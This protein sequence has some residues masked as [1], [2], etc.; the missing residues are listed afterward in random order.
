MLRATFATL[1]GYMFLI[2]FPA[3][4]Q[5]QSNLRAAEE[6]YDRARYDSSLSLLDTHTTDPAS[7]FLIGRDYYMLADFK[8]A[9]KFLKRA[10]RGRPE[11]SE[12]ADWLGRA[13]RA[14]ADTSNPLSAVL[15]T[16]RVR[17]SFERAVQLNPKNAG[18]LADLFYCYLET[19]VFLGGGSEKAQSIAEKMSAVDPYQASSQ[20]WEVAQKWHAKF[21]VTIAQEPPANK[22]QPA[23]LEAAGTQ[24]PL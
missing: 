7:L 3:F 5:N 6:L 1:I 15:L 18:A 10:V 4:A 16:K 14:R 12:Y 20:Q 8:R 9:A 17:N 11:S 2:S 24:L 13:Y 19:P 22:E 23:S 21:R